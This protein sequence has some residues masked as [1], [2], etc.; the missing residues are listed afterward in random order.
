MTS[1]VPSNSTLLGD[2]IAA[3]EV[4][5]RPDIVEQF[6]FITILFLFYFSLTN[7]FRLDPLQKRKKGSL[8]TRTDV[9]QIVHKGIFEC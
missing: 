7:P 3:G 5:R 9:A 4:L 1:E 8:Q 6:F 2:S